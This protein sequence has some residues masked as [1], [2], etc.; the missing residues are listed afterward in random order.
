MKPLVLYHKNCADGFTAA[1]CAVRGFEACDLYPATHGNNPPSL[2]GR[3]V[4]M[5][6]FSYKESVMRIL[7]EEA[8]SITILDHHKTAE[9]EMAQLNHVNKPNNVHCIFDMNKSGAQLAWEFFCHD[10]GSAPWLV[11][12][13]EDNDLGRWAFNETRDV[14]SSI[15][16]YDYTMENWDML[17]H[18]CESEVRLQNLIAEGVAISRKQDKDIRELLAVFQVTGNIG[19]YEVPM[20][21]MPYTF[22]TQAGRLMALGKPFSAVWYATKNGVEYSLRS[23]D[24]AIDVSE[25]AKIYGGGG[26]ARAAGFRLPYGKSLNDFAIPAG[27]TLP[28]SFGE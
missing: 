3:H 14:L 4:Y 25:I 9:A 7:A 15:Y 6:D 1:W 28:K 24:G 20:A 12:F 10:E 18:T 17:F 21:N 19:G 27:L 23:I 11:R 16:S 5:L 22:S 13:V 26:H 8:E 2:R